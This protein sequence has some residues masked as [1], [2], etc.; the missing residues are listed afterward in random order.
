MKTAVLKVSYFGKPFSGFAVQK[1]ALTVQGEIN[2]ALK[3]LFKREILTTCAGRTDKGVHAIGQVVS[4]FIN[5]EEYCKYKNDNDVLRL[6]IDSLV[7]PDIHINNVCLLDYEFSARF[8]AKSREYKYIIC[9]DVVPSVIYRSTSWHVPKLLDVDKMKLASRHL[10]GEHDFKSFCVA[11]SAKKLDCTDR[12]IKSI[13]LIEKIEY[14]QRIISIDV[15]G[16]AFLHSMIRNIVGSLV[17]VG[18]G[19]H[20]P[21]WIIDVLQS[22]DRSCAGLCA[23]ACGLI[24]MSVVY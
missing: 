20:K 9:N 3:T 16:N 14:N 21:E 1:E 13:T 15:V 5:D 10:I 8:D 24:F 6:S 17:E 4:F 22:K 7:H 11:S 19:K 23:P 18:I 2:K 12:C